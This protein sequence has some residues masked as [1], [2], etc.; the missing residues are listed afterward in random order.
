MVVILTVMSVFRVRV[1]ISHLGGMADAFAEVSLVLV[2]CVEIS[3]HTD[4]LSTCL[5][6]QDWLVTGRET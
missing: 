2:T 6:D 4:T 3:R 5:H 1:L